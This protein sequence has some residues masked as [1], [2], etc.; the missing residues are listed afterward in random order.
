[1][2]Y[3]PLGQNLSGKPYC[4][5]QTELGPI[6]YLEILLFFVNYCIDEISV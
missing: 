1:M 4:H 3:L 5:L 2:G 6:L